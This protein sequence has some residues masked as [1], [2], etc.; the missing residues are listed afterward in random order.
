MT[1]RIH[2]WTRYR[3]LENAFDI[4]HGQM[5]TETIQR[6]KLEHVQI[7]IGFYI[8]SFS[9][10]FVVEHSNKALCTKF[11]FVCA[12]HHIH[13][14]APLARLPLLLV[15]F[16]GVLLQFQVIEILQLKHYLSLNVIWYR[17]LCDLNAKP[18]IGFFSFE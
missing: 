9:I 16:H 2:S 4:R 1:L 7:I 3:C 17:I 14:F 18:L 8:F 6:T 10:I 5:H 13:T 12:T 15:C 11:F